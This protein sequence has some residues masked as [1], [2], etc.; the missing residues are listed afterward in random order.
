[1]DRVI[2]EY[3]DWMIDWLIGFNTFS[4]KF[5]LIHWMLFS[6]TISRWEDRETDNLLQHLPLSDARPQ[7]IGRASAEAQVSRR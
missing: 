4:V 5:P 3:I 7:E 6:R 1:M 2:D